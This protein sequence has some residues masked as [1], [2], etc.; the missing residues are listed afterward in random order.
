MSSIAVKNKMTEGPLLSG[1]FLF[2]IPLM[3]TG[4]LQLLYNAADN[5][6]VGRFSGDPN[7]LAAVGSTASFNSLTVGL[8]M[9]ISAGAGVVVAQFYGAKRFSDV[10]RIVHTALM[11]SLI[12]GIVIS[13]VG[14]IFCKPILLLMGTKEEII[15]KSALYMNIIFLGVPAVSV[16]NSG[17]SVLRSTGDSKTPLLILSASGVLNVILNLVFVICFKMTVD[18]VALAT[19]IS[20]Y[21]SAVLVLF[22]LHRSRDCFAFRFKA[23]CVDKRFLCRILAL[24]IPSG[25]QSSLFS[26][27]N[28]LL[29]SAVNTFSVEVISGNTIGN[30]IEGFTYTCMNSFYQ[31]AL[32]YTGQ[33]YGAGNRKRVNKVLIYSLA[34]VTAVGLFLGFTELAFGRQL[35]AMFT[36]AENS[37]AVIEAAVARISL[38]LPLY[39]LCGIMEVLTGFLR[40]LGCSTVPMISSLV[41]ACL[42]RVVWISFFFPLPAFNNPVGIYISYPISW[43]LTCTFH[44]LTIAVVKRRDPLFKKQRAEATA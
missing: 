7:A 33:N 29:Q 37:E 6:V 14:L 38:I 39:F 27:S 41:G 11:F 26:L 3:L 8:L 18:G 42:F 40:G 25:I 28:M 44:L 23:L 35:S 15:D 24:G 30:Q 5:I 19:V 16:L 32:M 36:D 13:V 9:G 20:Q 17:A 43:I 12:C 22:C 1:I 2:S 4:I 34:L 10:P 21:L 31:A